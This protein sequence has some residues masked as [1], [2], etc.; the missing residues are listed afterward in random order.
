MEENTEI[1]EFTTSINE[2]E[3]DN[4]QEQSDKPKGKTVPKKKQPPKTGHGW[5]NDT[6]KAFE[7]NEMHRLK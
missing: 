5:M 6:K 1:Q 4:S 7:L 2:N 3:I